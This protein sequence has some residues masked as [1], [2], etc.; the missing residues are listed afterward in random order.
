[1][2]NRGHLRLLLLALFVSA[3]TSHQAH[4]TA[5]ACLVSMAHLSEAA[6]LV[7]RG[8]CLWRAK[9]FLTWV[10]GLGTEGVT[11]MQIVSPPDNA[12]H[13]NTRANTVPF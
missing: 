1:M 2:M 8:V 10:E 3:F 6:G 9:F 11:T 7:T 12:F 4:V 13:Q 5:I